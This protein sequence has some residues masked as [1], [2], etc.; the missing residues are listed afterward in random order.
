M[1]ES[2]PDDQLPANGKPLALFKKFGGELASIGQERQS[3]KGA[4]NP[5][6][7]GTPTALARSG[8]CRETASSPPRNGRACWMS[9]GP[10]TATRMANGGRG[11]AAAGVPTPAARW[12]AY[13]TAVDIRELSLDAIADKP[14]RLTSVED[15]A[16][17]RYG[18]RRP[19]RR[20]RCSS[21]AITWPTCHMM[22]PGPRWPTGAKPGR[23]A[24]IGPTG[25]LLN[26]VREERPGR[27]PGD[28]YLSVVIKE[29]PPGPHNPTWRNGRS[30][31]H[32]QTRALL[33]AYG[34]RIPRR[35]GHGRRGRDRRRDRRADRA[36]KARCARR[37]AAVVQDD[38]RT[39][40]PA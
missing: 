13:Y 36:G 7:S 11:R 5:R 27:L 38:R 1:A 14:G 32:Y 21:P 20:R 22:A 24:A 17:L 39:G 9:S 23:A 12:G 33:W 31:Y 4:A 28:C 26:A 35:G 19:I 8:T 10:S 2:I 18:R 37:A 15:L 6:S 25:D 34:R 30:I 3:V 40:P 29:A 16:G